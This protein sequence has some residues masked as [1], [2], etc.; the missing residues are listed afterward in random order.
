YPQFESYNRF[1]VFDNN[2][3]VKYMIHRSTFFQF[4]YQK[5]T[6][7]KSKGVTPDTDILTLGDLLGST[8]EKIKNTLTRG[9]GFISINANLLDAKRV[10][11]ATD[12]CQ[13]VFVTQNGKPSEPVL[14]LI[15][16]NRIF[17]FAKV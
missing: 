17:G 13:D 14:G 5:Y 1:A 9:I 10:I 12:E 8:D 11:D 6:E 7:Q 15:T 2:K 3:V 4:I 16:N